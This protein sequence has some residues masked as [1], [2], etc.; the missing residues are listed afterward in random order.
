MIAQ[1][2]PAQEL[3]CQV[4]VV[5]QNIQSTNLDIFTSMENDIYQFM[6]N[7]KWTSHVFSNEEKI[8]CSI[9]INLT[10]QIGADR[11]KAQLTVQAGRPI[12]NTSYQSS[13]LN[14]Q[15]ADK[16]LVFQYLPNQPL[17]FNENIYIYELTSVLAYYA[18]I[19]LGLDYDTFSKEGGTPYFQ[20]ALNIVNLAQ[21]ATNSGIGW[22]PTEGQT[23]RY[24]L[25]ENIVK[26]AFRPLRQ[27]YY[28]YHMQ[29]LDVMESRQQAGRTQIARALTSLKKVH[30]RLPNAY[31]TSIF[32]NSKADE[33]VKCFSNA[34]DAE[35]KR[36]FDV[37]KEVNA[38]NLNKYKKMLK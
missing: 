33:I 32:F 11:F 10:E 29:G 7:T 18:Y 31:F 1:M 21:S 14:L 27:A 17:D 15:E 34:T 24:W 3:N 9:Q 38:G 37:L 5:H 19:I 2:G 13:I 26:E 28:T 25:V 36:V 6:N 8:E 23:N 4:K 16:S 20:K 30:S 12:Y 35:K 22:R